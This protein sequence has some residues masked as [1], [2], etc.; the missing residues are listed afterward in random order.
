MKPTGAD[1]RSCRRCDVCSKKNPRMM[2]LRTQ[3]RLE[4]EASNY[5][6]DAMIL[7]DFAKDNCPMCA[8]KDCIGLECCKP[9]CFK[10]GGRDH[11][12]KD[13]V[14]SKRDRLKKILSGKKVCMRCFCYIEWSH[15]NLD[16][17]SETTREECVAGEKNQTYAGNDCIISPQVQIKGW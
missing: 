6:T 5:A 12:S 10:C 17:S 7:L 13:C 3:M 15:C 9:K 1:V 2:Q 4:A 11:F 14:L 8:R 16:R